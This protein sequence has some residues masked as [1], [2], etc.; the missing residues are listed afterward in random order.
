MKILFADLDGTLLDDKSRVSEYSR[1][2][3]KRMTDAGHKLVL[4]SG[5]PLGSILE[6]KALAGLDMAGVYITANNG[7]LIY[8]CD[9]SVIIYKDPVPME[10]VR[11]LWDMAYDMGVHIQTYTDD[12][13]VT[14]VH[15]AEID[16]YTVKIHL[17]VLYV[18]DP[19]E[20]LKS[21]PSKML[22]ISLDDPERLEAFRQGVLAGF[23][24]TLD[25]LYSNAWYLE[26]Y[27]RTAGKGEGLKWLCSH[28]G[29]PTEDSYAAGDAM[30]DISMIEAAGHG[31]AMLNGDAEVRGRAELITEYS[32]D[33]D[34]LARFIER[35]ILKT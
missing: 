33:E 34:G 5:R 22:A 24:D 17:P 6:I 30:N 31:I 23:G 20:A 8:D 13:I 18:D 14:R 7:A 1:D 25:A 9:R 15:D 4:A 10:L 3:L 12:H 19:A 27:S 26:I 16:K 2:V 29:I 32:N 35:E 28:L 11:P 21:P